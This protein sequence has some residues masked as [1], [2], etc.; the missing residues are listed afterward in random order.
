MNEN[1]LIP[2]AFPPR[3]QALRKYWD[4]LQI[5]PEC[6]NILELAYALA[7]VPPT[8][9]ADGLAYIQTQISR[10]DPTWP[11]VTKLY[12]FVGYIR[13]FWLRL[14]NVVSV[15]GTA[16]R[17]N[18]ICEVFHSHAKDTIGAHQQLWKLLGKAHS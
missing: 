10:F 3:F 2:V 15:Y 8:R 14:A 1:L 6:E 18:N 4:K 17:T 13:R 5:R 9:M 16:I 7:H 12:T 11:D